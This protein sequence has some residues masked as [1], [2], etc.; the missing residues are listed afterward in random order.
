VE[1][2]IDDCCYI[3][4]SVDSSIV[5]GDDPVAAVSSK[6]RGAAGVIP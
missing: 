3:V 5:L 2:A 4:Y 6:K 1:S